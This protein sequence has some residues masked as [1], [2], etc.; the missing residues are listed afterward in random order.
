MLGEGEMKGTSVMERGLPPA[1]T[2]WQVVQ[3]FGI[4]FALAVALQYVG[5]RIGS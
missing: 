2:V 5:R 3:L 1:S 4:P